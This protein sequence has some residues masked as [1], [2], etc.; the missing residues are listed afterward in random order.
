MNRS[1]SFVWVLGLVWLVSASSAFGESGDDKYKTAIAEARKGYETEVRTA[2]SKY[3]QALQQ[4]MTKATQAGDLDAAVALRE[5]IKASKEM[6]TTENIL[7][8]K[9]ANTEW[10]NS[11]NVRLA[12]DSKG[13]LQHG[14]TKKAVECVPIDGKRVAIVFSNNRV[15]VLIFND[16][17]TTFEQWG[18]ESKDRPLF[19]G[20]RTKAPASRD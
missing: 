15:A 18:Q 1:Q 8:T 16:D 9:L 4:L 10:T 11:N 3:V 17:F 6:P 14:P 5:T 20:K 2:T 13:R 12:W 7:V 19:T